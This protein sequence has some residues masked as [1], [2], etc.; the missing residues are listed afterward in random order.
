MN[1]EELKEFHSQEVDV[2]RVFSVMSAAHLNE[3]GVSRIRFAIANNNGDALKFLDNGE[4]LE[5]IAKTEEGKRC[6]QLPPQRNTVEFQRALVGGQFIL[7]GN[8]YAHRVFYKDVYGD[9]Q[10]FNIHTLSNTYKPEA[11]TPE[12]DVE[13]KKTEYGTMRAIYWDAFNY[14]HLRSGIVEN[15]AYG[16]V[17][18]DFNKRPH[19]KQST[20]KVQTLVDMQNEMDQKIEANKEYEEL[21]KEIKAKEE[22]ERAKQAEVQVAQKKEEEQKKEEARKKADIYEF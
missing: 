20:I 12:Q 15:L 22:A 2:L 14:E 4:V 18:R 17:E 6:F 16:P 21:Q 1:Q 8:Y 3:D 9:F 5:G 11:N 19:D 10:M 13:L 7:E